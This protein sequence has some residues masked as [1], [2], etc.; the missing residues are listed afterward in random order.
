[1]ERNN[2][3]TNL[4]FILS[5]LTGIIVLVFLFFLFPRQ[6]SAQ[7]FSLSISPPIT[8]IIIQPGKSYTQTFTVKNNGGSVVIMPKIYP[9]VPLDT[10]GHAEL[11]E[12]QNSVD[13]FSNW[14][15]FDR[16]GISIGT[17]GSH[18]FTLK[19]TPPESAE[20]KDYYFTFMV[21]VI[22][23]NNLGVN[24]SQAKARI[25]ANL[26]VS[27]SKDGNPPKKASIIEFSA[28]KII[29][30]FMDLTYKIIL[31][32]Y[33]Q[34]LYKPVGKITVDQIFGKTTTLNLAPLNIL[35]GGKREIA[36]VYEE[37]LDTCKLPDRFIIGIFSSNLSFTVDGTGETIEK[38][39]YTVAFPFSAV[40]ALGVIFVIY[41]SIKR[42]GA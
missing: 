42:M 24:N 28:P 2:L 1:M 4:K 7:E 8:E 25:G 30:S 36:C 9:F 12:D 18:N 31:G 15:Y 6:V 41:R 19:I 22:N 26:L 38:Q 17:T 16:S 35:V 20:E 32:N 10:Q 14:F 5:G 13:A 33:G 11:I 3:K 23:D 40:L 21:E 29:D 37:T 39:V 27:V 34:S